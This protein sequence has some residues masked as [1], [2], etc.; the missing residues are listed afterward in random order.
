MKPNDC[1]F[2]QIAKT[3][4]AAMKF[5]S[6]RTAPYGLTVVQS[7]VLAFLSDADGVTS[8]DSGGADA[9]G[10]RHA[11]WHHRPLGSGRVRAAGGNTPRTAG[12]F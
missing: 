6:D 12:P 2:F 10:Q 9:T 7:M 1:I 5:L 8:A 4:Q 3:H 11:H